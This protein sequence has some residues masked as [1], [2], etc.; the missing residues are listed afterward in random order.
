MLVHFESGYGIINKIQCHLV[1]TFT[2]MLLSTQHALLINDWTVKILETR[3]FWLCN[4]FNYI[5][6]NQS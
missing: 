3:E 6:I 1:F 4:I 5:M 2:N